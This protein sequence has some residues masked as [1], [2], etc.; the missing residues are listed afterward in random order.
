MWL[1][2]SLKCHSGHLYLNVILENVRLGFH[3]ALEHT[4]CIRNGLL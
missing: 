3:A 4:A 2:L 1:Q